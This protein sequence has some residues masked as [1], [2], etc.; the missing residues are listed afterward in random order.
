MSEIRDMYN[1]QLD[2]DL[3]SGKFKELWGNFKRVQSNSYFYAFKVLS[4]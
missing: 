1:S 3:S 4:A 2:A